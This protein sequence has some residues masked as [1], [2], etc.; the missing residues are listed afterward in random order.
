MSPYFKIPELSLKESPFDINMDVFGLRE[1]TDY[2]VK[3]HVNKRRSHQLHIFI[4]I[5]TKD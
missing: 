4:R 5:Q 1:E 2:S 3:T